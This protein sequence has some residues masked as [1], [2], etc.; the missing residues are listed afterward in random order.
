M[1]LA[2][3]LAI[4]LAARRDES[5]PGVDLVMLRFE[6]EDGETAVSLALSMEMATELADGLVTA[7]ETLEAVRARDRGRFN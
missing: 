4:A 1:V 6:G 5:V 2:R 3:T 7:F